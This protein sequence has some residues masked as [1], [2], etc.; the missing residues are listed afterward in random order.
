MTYDGTIWLEVP[1][2][3]K[4]IPGLQSLN[5]VGIPKRSLDV[6]FGGNFNLSVG[7]YIAV[8]VSEVLKRKPEYQDVLN[9]A[10]PFGVDDTPGSLGQF[11]P[12]WLKRII[13]REMEESSPEFARTYQLIWL[14][15]QYKARE[16][17][18]PPVSPEQINKMTKDFYSMRTVANL[19]LPFS[20]RFNT[21][22]RYYI[23]KWQEFQRA[24]GKDAEQQFL[25]QFGEEFFMFATN[26]SQN[27]SNVQASVD[28][29]NNIQSNKG[30]VGEVYQIEPALV[31]L[32]VNNPTGY[33]FSSAIYDW[34]YREK[35]G[36]GTKETF[37]SDVNPVEAQ[38]RNEA[39]L[40]WLKYRDLM[41]FIDAE[42][43]RRNLTNVNKAPDLATL[44]T[45][46]ISKIAQGNIAWY[47]DYRDV[48]GSK[49][50]RAIRG[51][52]T[53][54]SDEEFMKKN[55]NNSTWRTVKAYL[56]LRNDLAAM[57]QQRNQGTIDNQAN[58]DIRNMYDAI[59]AKLKKD[60]IN[61][62]DMYDRFLSQDKVYDKYLAGVK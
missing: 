44:K 56:M 36:P 4:K 21:P 40:G 10:L 29:Y 20:P 48:D 26:L 30:L 5:N 13:T 51:L 33:D 2:P 45:A 7:P 12:T 15:E 28:A 24:Y 11:V 42:L 25:N 31:G 47:E 43:E 60:D 39:K 58:R 61:F 62:A 1:E 22:Y 19:I 17:G 16:E 8:P 49:T 59:V 23:D 50:L 27:K 53:I 41:N 6:V 32:L 37:R 52:E 57:L 54:I 3:L 38:R 55:A 9:W 35:I 34:Q 14:T 46:V 18:R